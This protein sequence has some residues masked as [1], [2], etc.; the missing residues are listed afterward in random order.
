MLTMNYISGFPHSHLH[1][2]LSNFTE[3]RVLW[4]KVNRSIQLDFCFIFYVFTLFRQ[5]FSSLSLFQ[6]KYS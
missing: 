2:L 4:E 3:F 5:I 1:L 6:M